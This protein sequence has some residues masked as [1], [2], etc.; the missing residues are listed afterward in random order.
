VQATSPQKG[1]LV[2]HTV[3]LD[4]CTFDFDATEELRRVTP[5]DPNK[6]SS[7]QYIFNAHS[8]AAIDDFSGFASIVAPTDRIVFEKERNPRLLMWKPT[9]PVEPRFAI[10]GSGMENASRSDGCAFG[11]SGVAKAE[12]DVVAFCKSVKITVADGK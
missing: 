4:Y 11:C 6:Y 1:K 12:A 2:H 7:A 10:M 9:S 3:K 8:G 5:D